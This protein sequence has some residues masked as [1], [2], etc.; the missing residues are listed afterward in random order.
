LGKAT[1]QEMTMRSIGNSIFHYLCISLKYTFVILLLTALMVQTF[2]RSIAMADYMVN[3]EAYKKACVNKA[4]PMLHCNGK[5]QMLKK[6]KKQEGD[7]EA[8]APILKLNH[9][10][11]VLS[12]KSFFPSISVVSTNNS[13]SY[14]TYTD[15]YSS[16]YLGA[17]FHPPSI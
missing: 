10:E 3:L 1:I 16:D 2:S 9:L 15:D 14:F 8:S 13:S 4:K 12:S 5:C 6:V 7:S 17:I 11:V